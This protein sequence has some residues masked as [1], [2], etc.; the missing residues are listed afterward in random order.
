MFPEGDGWIYPPYGAEIH[1]GKLY[2]RGSMDDKGPIIAALYGLKAIADCDLK[3]S[4][5][6]RILFGTNEET[7][8]KE[9]EYYLER[10]KPPVLGFTPD[11]EYPIIYAEKGITIFNV[12]KDL[13]SKQTGD[14]VIKRI[15]G[16]QV[17]N[18]VPDYCEAEIVVKDVN[19]TK[20]KLAKFVAE[21][22]HDIKLE[23]A[24]GKLIL[25]SNGAAAH[26]STPELGKNAIMQLF[27]LHRKFKFRKM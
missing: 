11:A 18:M 16:G 7:G 25:K 2:A 23:E 5:R 3:L 6:V 8:S 9:L 24:E 19:E 27:R 13:N 21:T 1:D 26:G 15:K 14:F 4:K 12:V 17:P 10:E 22:G 20:A